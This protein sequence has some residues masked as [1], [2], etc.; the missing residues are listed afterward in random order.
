MTKKDLSTSEQNAHIGLLKKHLA[1]VY[2]ELWEI[3][4]PKSK[5]ETKV[6]Y[7]GNREGIMHFTIKGWMDGVKSKKTFVNIEIFKKY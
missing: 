7:F 2:K 6:K 1:K 5:I 4:F 3:E